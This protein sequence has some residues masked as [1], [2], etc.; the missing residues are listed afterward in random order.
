MFL[1]T[2]LIFVTAGCRAA[3]NQMSLSGV[4]CVPEGVVGVSSSPCARWCCRLLHT[5]SETNQLLLPGSRAH[6]PLIFRPSTD[7]KHLQHVQVVGGAVSPCYL[8]WFFSVASETCVVLAKDGTRT[9]ASKMD[10][11]PPCGRRRGYR[12]NDRSYASRPR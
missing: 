2:L 1:S 9:W 5:D 7:G 4:S 12:K 11:P 10:L 6:R 3:L 8:L